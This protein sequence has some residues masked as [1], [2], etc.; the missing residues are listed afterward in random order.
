MKVTYARFEKFRIG[1]YTKRLKVKYLA[2]HLGYI[3][4]YFIGKN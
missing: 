4:L 3:S 1:I 2:L